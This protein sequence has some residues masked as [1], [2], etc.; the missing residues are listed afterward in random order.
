MATDAN[1]LLSNYPDLRQIAD[2]LSESEANT[3][4]RQAD[5]DK[6]YKNGMRSIPKSFTGESY[7]ISEFYTNGQWQETLMNKK[8]TSEEFKQDLAVLID[9]R[10]PEAIRIHLFSENKKVGA[11]P[12]H[13]KDV[14]IKDTFE[15]KGVPDINDDTKELVAKIERQIANKGFTGGTSSELLTEKFNRQLDGIRADHEKKDAINKL[16]REI[17]K[18]DAQIV[19]LND[20]IED[21]E[22]DVSDYEK[23]LLGIQKE[24]KEYR[25]PPFLKIMSRI[26]ENAG[27]NLLKSNPK[28]TQ[29][30][31]GL[32]LKEITEIWEEVEDNENHKQLAEN[33]ESDTVEVEFEDD[34]NL[35]KEQQENFKIIVKFLKSLQ[36]E[37]FEMVISILASLQNKDGT[38][39]EELAKKLVASLIIFQ[40]NNQNGTAKESEKEVEKI[41]SD[42]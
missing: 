24:F 22:D 41:E 3:A 15:E 35:S 31:T 34:S 28:F 1:I 13:V 33:A 2:R 39:N 16:Q 23:G 36:S 18:R 14:V 9:R 20:E 25:E 11:A 27:T 17:D 38:L 5:Y 40:K 10:D 26:A 6:K 21:L 32:E 19:A 4:K 8:F 42:D 37:N 12:I 29:A 30:L 7:C